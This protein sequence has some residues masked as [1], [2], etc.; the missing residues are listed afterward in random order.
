MTEKK[1]IISD[2]I[3]SAIYNNLVQQSYKNV[4]ELIKAIEK[5]IRPV[6]EEEKKAT[7]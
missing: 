1:F 3:L 7:N 2:G 5:D 4:S 6:Q